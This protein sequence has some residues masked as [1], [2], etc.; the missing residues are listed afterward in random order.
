VTTPP[1]MLK[2]EGRIRPRIASDEGGRY[3]NIPRNQ[4][5]SSFTSVQGTGCGTVNATALIWRVL[6]VAERR[7]RKLDAPELLGAIAQ[8]ER[9]VD[10]QFGSPNRRAVA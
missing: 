9:C 3:L 4:A 5:S 10:G 8:G 6:M 1:V 7:F 2:S